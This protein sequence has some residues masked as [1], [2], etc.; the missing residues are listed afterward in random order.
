MQ[1]QGQPGGA[2]AIHGWH[3]PGPMF[4]E[5]ASGQNAQTPRR[6]PCRIPGRPEDILLSARPVAPGINGSRR[7]TWGWSWCFRAR[8]N[9]IGQSREPKSKLHSVDQRLGQPVAGKGRERPERS[10]E[11]SDGSHDFAACAHALPPAKLRVRH[12]DREA[13]GRNDERGHPTN[14]RGAE[15]GSCLVCSGHR[16]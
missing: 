7:S 12:P 14:E 16:R 8:G 2:D 13:R 5:L 1:V 6:P 15:T 3:G 4:E 9:K 10:H 11:Q